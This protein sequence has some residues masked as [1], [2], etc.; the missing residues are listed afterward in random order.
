MQKEIFQYEGNMVLENGS[1][2]EKP[3][4]TYHISGDDTTAEKPVVWICHALTANSD[5]TAWWPGLVGRGRFYDPAHYTIVCANILG[6]CYGTTGP[7][8]TNPDTGK[9]WLLSFPSI[10]MR[11]IVRGH[12][13]LRKHL[14]IDRIHT[15]AGGSI[16]G[17]QALEW[18][19]MEPA[20]FQNL[21]L[22]ATGSKATPWAIAINETERMAIEADQGFDGEDS[23]GGKKGLAAA[24]AIGLLSYRSYEAYNITQQEKSGVITSDFRA[25]SYQRYQGK[26]LAHRFNTYCY[27]TLTKAQDT[28]NVGRYRGG[29]AKALGKIQ[30][31]TLSI[32]IE[33]D[34]LFPPG[35][36]E[37][38]ARHTPGA[39][40]RIIQS[41]YGHD[42]FL[43][44]YEQ[45]RQ[46]LESFYQTN[47]TYGQ[48][49]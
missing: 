40:F 9:P 36:Q 29:V 19:I 4:I 28:H 37:Y 34:G 25:S 27:H 42:G 22:I 23:E 7:A 24:R 32:G 3:V 35:E 45:I 14:G 6:S 38:I 48:P 10:T 18:A 5:P 21:F 44:E 12:I 11:D 47:D 30:A 13:M 43:L 46:V 33:S 41:Q 20:I 49:K 8:N 31:N 17:F 39:S 1:I 16:G 2:I 26:K 15:L